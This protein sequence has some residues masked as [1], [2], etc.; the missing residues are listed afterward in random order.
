V[1]LRPSTSNLTWYAAIDCCFRVLFRGFT[2]HTRARQVGFGDTPKLL[3]SCADIEV[4]EGRDGRFYVV[5]TARVFPPEAPLASIAGFLVPCDPSLGVT[6]IDINR[7]RAADEIVAMIGPNVITQVSGATLYSP[8]VGGPHNVRASAIAGANIHG[9]AVVVSGERGQHLY[10]TL[11]KELVKKSPSPLSS[12]AFTLFGR[13][14]AHVHNSEVREATA[15]M[16][17]SV[18]PSLTARL[19]SRDVMVA[20]P[21]QL[22]ASLHA[23]GIN[24]RSEFVLSQIHRVCLCMSFGLCVLLVSPVAT[25]AF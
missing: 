10:F 23:S 20:H 1:L 18:L 6:L 24:I 9:D 14:D 7:P 11:R 3:A 17:Q 21:L 16:L 15:I 2:R 25:S 4:H 8:S 5:D 22:E 12:D 19:L 13:H